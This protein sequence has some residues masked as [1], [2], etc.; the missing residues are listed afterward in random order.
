[1]RRNADLLESMMDGG[2]ISQ[3]FESAAVFAAGNNQT[4]DR[5]IVEAPSV[6][7]SRQQKL[8]VRARRVLLRLSELEIFP[9]TI[10]APTLSVHFAGLQIGDRSLMIF[11]SFA[12]TILAQFACNQADDK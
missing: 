8:R 7:R 2:D 11:Q 4:N 3:Q 6:H 5:R 12:H 10:V 9:G 1:M